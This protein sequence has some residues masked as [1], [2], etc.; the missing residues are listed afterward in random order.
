MPKSQ[1][2]QLDQDPVF[3]QREWRVQRVG[4]W[5]LVIFVAAAAAGA[6]GHGPLSRV[7]AATP[8]DAVVVEYERFVRSGAAMRLE[9]HRQSSTAGRLEL[10]LDR[11]YADRLRIERITPEP[12]SIDVGAADVVMTFTTPGAGPLTIVID[13]EPLRAGRLSAQIRTTGAPPVRVS[14]FVYF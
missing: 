3:Q 13:A 4:W 11:S 7:R 12:E 5:V 1:T 14:Q 6:F 9:I 10:R 2:L 8:G